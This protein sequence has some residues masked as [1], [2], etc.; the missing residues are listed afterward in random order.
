MKSFYKQVKRAGAGA[1]VSASL[2]CGAATVTETAVEM[3][4]YP[5]FDPDPV[6]ATSD[7]RYPYFFFDG[8]SSTNVCR[9]W[10]AVVL[11]SDRLKVTILPEIGGKV[12][13]ATDKATGR[14]FIYHNHVVKFRNVARRGPWCSGGI[15][16]NF[17]I[18]G[19]TP[20]TATPVS[21]YVLDNKDGRVSCFLSDTELVCRTMWQVEVCL[22]DGKDSFVTRTTWFN[23]SNFFTP[24]Y[25]W[26][27]AAYSVRGD[28]EFFFPGASY[29]G[30]AGDSHAWPVDEKGRN[31][32]RYS[33]NAFGQN[34]SYHVLDGDHSFYGI[35]W[36]E[37]GIGS[38][39]ENPATQ[40][41]GRKIWLWGLSRE[42][43]IWEDLL[44]D[45][46]GQYTEL[47]SGL[48]F[49]QPADTLKTPFKHTAFAP[50]ATETFEEK[51]GV[52]RSRAELE[53]RM[54][55]TNFVKRPQTMPADFDWTTAYGLY[56]K[57]RQ[58]IR[59]RM[60][61]DGE[62]AL[63]ECLAKEPYYV[64]ALEELASLAVRR[65]K[66]A[67]AH[68]FA[69]KA[70]AVDT[71]TPGANYAE[72]QAFFAEGCLRAAKERLGIAARTPEF[73]AAALVLAA[74]AALREGKWDEAGAF[75]KKAFLANGNNFDAW[76]V[77]TVAKRKSG[78]PAAFTA[79][80]ILESVPLFHAAR[81][82]LNLADPGSEPMETYV[83]CEFP[84]EVY[85]E[86]GSWY[87]ESGLLEDAEALFRKAAA[88]SPVG[89]IC[90]AYVLRCAGKEA[91]A[92][93]ALDAAASKPVA[94]ALPFRR[95]SIPALTWAEKTRPEWKFKYLAA[96][97]LAANAWDKEAD[98]LLADCAEEPDDAVFYLYRASRR[99]GEMRLPDLR[100]AA[101][102]GASWRPG[103][104]LYRYFAEV[105][106]WKSA[107]K[108]IEPYVAKYP[109]AN[110]V[111]LA[112]ANALA[113]S[114]RYEKAVDYLSRIT[115]L[116][117]EHGDNA[118]TSWLYAWRC[119]ASNALSL[120]K[121]EVAKAA[122]AK[123]LSFPENLGRGKPY[124]PPEKGTPEAPGLLAD[125]P[126]SL[127]E[128]VPEVW[129]TSN[130]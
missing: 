99:K 73:R 26:M 12:W 56:L 2:F 116:P 37:A 88:A 5:F 60:D 48:F 38:F 44:T 46:D 43:G 66:Y 64:P 40:K 80:W 78:H 106:D 45:N 18:Y 22:E 112:Y 33:N 70:L 50:G 130:H 98:A 14:D 19:H 49:N 75:A 109:D 89:G 124:D 127:L 107:L 118:F 1:F 51:W 115:V 126:D 57:G 77:Q 34:K 113:R 32:A 52:V 120:G 119:I 79:K 129:E 68:T 83:R 97:C 92:K 17:G 74:K 123:A 105:E 84:H 95:E 47:Q 111:K 76:L 122:V 41:Y 81:Y 53:N 91:E 25:H 8:T 30:H 110:L 87:E 13:G 102:Y 93:A 58:C 85:L 11:E 62:K 104:A 9:T 72:G 114:G 24:F 61:R 63:L 7:M 86:I 39:H 27:N 121:K 55:P 94:F 67:V 21:Y 10:K 20:S 108:E 69:E 16:F 125:W 65:G 35:W 54:N 3:P 101:K 96:V 31:L 59:R 23:G 90:L 36:P 71:Y 117:S 6:P 42:G 28:P 100:S 4:T 29:I 103:Y 82:E 128:L 15:E